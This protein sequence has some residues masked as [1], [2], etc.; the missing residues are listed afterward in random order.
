M[1]SRWATVIDPATF[2][3]GSIS[4]SQAS[5]PIPGPETTAGETGC[6]SLAVE[7]GLSV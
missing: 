1:G 5:N 2:L 6:S 3:I 4:G 7:V